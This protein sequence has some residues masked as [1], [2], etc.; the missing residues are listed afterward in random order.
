MLKSAGLWDA[1]LHHEHPP[2]HALP[3]QCHVH[4]RV[5]CHPFCHWQTSPDSDLQLKMDKYNPQFDVVP[6]AV[7]N[8]LATALVNGIGIA[9]TL[10]GWEVGTGLDI[11]WKLVH[12]W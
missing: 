5:H 4:H 9:G 12:G 6:L 11:E 2:A 1:E 10:V 8:I 7:P 3:L